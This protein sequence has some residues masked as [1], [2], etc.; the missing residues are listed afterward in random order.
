MPDVQANRQQWDGTYRW[1]RGGDEWSIAWGSADTEW[2]WSL[3][4]RLRWLLPART[5]LEI[6]PGYGRWTQYLLACCERYVGIDLSSECV[7]ACRQRFADADHAEF[8]VNDGRSLAAVADASIEVAFS[9][10]SLVHVEDDVIDAYTSELARVL[11]P[12]GVAFLH[13]SNLAAC[14]P[15][16]GPLQLGLHVAERALRRQTP[17]FDHWRGSTMSA[18]RLEELAD[19]AGL[20]C[21]G[22]EVVNWGGGR[23]IDCISL[24]T[25]RGS[26]WERPNLVV[27]NPYFMAEA[28]SGARAAQVH[29]AV[30]A[31]AAWRTPG[32]LGTLHGLA[33]GSI[34]PWRLSLMGPWPSKTA[35]TARGVRA[36]ARRRARTP[37]P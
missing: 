24:L 7:E 36:D 30:P 18:Q 6:A 34:G 4:P 33:S 1:P 22:Q 21:I 15:I 17:G 29:T 12:D 31:P 37:R 28:E 2:Q 3:W 35:T 25:P 32:R 14:R 5:V 23:L 27:E 20:A 26:R 19:Q 16:R 11:T 8:H 13:H 9:F 10:D